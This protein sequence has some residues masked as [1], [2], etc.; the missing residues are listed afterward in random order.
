[1][2]FLH[3]SDKGCNVVAQKVPVIFIEMQNSLVNAS[4]TLDL[5]CA[6]QTGVSKTGFA[7]I[8]HS[9]KPGGVN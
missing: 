8:W 2:R 3:I 7:C 9:F 6:V 1:M 5:F 4:L